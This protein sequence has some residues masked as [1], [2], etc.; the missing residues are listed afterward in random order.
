M[1]REGGQG[2]GGHRGPDLASPRCP[3]DAEIEVDG[4]VFGGDL[5]PGFRTWRDHSYSSPRSPAS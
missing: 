3:E 5:L 1:G 2:T 4:A